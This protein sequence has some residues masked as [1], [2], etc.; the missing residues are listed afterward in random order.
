VAQDL[1]AAIPCYRLIIRHG[2]FDQESEISIAFVGGGASVP[3][4]RDHAES[5]AGRQWLIQ[6]LHPTQ[7]LTTERPFIYNCPF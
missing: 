7:V 1:N 6:L 3:D 4:A 5:M 2:A